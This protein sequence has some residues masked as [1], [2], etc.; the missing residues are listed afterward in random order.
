MD[1]GHLIGYALVG[2][3]RGFDAS[4]SNPKNIATQ[5]AWANQANSN[6][7]TGQNYYETLVR[8]ALDRHKAVRYRVTLIYDRDNLL[9]SGSHIEAKSSD[10]SLEF[11]VFIPNVQS[12]LLFDYATG[13]VKQTK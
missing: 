8:K 13:K 4:T 12:G 10:G 7:S 9:S 6:Q 2:S 3:L 1:R 5:A 11:N